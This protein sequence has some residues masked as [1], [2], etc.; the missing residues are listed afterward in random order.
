[1]GATVPAHH[2]RIVLDTAASRGASALE[3]CASVGLDPAL[4]EDMEARTPAAVA[5]ALY[6]RAAEE[7][8]DSALGLHVAER[9]DF[10]AFD[11]L[12]FAIA[13]KKNL[14]EA[15]DHL[16]PA[17][18]ALHGT[19]M[20]LEVTG[21]AAHLSYELP[22]EAV[23]PCRH[24]AEA[25]M[26]RTVRMLALATGVGSRPRRVAFKH[27]RPRDVSEH[28]RVFGAPLAFGAPR[29]ELVVDAALL[30]VPFVR[31]DPRL[32]NVLDQHVRDLVARMPAVQSLADQVRRYIRDAVPRG[33]FDLESIGRRMGM[34]GRTLQRGLSTEGSSHRKIVEQVRHEFALHYLGETRMPIKEVA[35]LLGY[36]ELRAFYRA[37]ERWTGLP[38]AAY[39]RSA[40]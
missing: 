19:G 4:P 21:D 10:F 29:H 23:Q 2:L 1:M 13:A 5:S 40:K 31:A 30:D 6:E 26:A 9:S 32:S 20:E 8:G 37:F 33:D 16:G 3:L 39:R 12:G 27:A 28:E 14:R 35:T 7:T 38:P 11:A 24:R 15:F 17:I 36:S 34:G 25:Y 22:E 18:S